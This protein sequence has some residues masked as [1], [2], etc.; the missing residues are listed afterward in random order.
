DPATLHPHL[1][2]RLLESEINE[3]LARD[4]LLRLPDTRGW[5]TQS[6]GPLAEQALADLM[7]REIS[8][9]GPIECLPGKVKVVALIGPTGVGKTTTIAKLAAQFALTE[10]RKVGLLTMDTYR[11]AAVEQLKMYSQIIDI[12]IRVAYSAADIKPALE[13]LADRDLV[14]IDTAGRSQKNSMQVGELKSVLD[15]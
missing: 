7:A 1:Y 12:P 8:G 15:S 2:A 11:I 6:R 9:A 14:L 13:E 5:S 10:K 3:D 4:L